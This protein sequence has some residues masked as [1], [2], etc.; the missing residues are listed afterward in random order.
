[1]ITSIGG[2]ELSRA[3]VIAMVRADAQDRAEEKARR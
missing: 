3:T 2:M 1:V